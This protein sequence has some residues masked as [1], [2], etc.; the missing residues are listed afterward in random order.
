MET[1][2][3]K[4]FAFVQI[5]VR[6]KSSLWVSSKLDFPLTFSRSM[7]KTASVSI[8]HRK[9]LSWMIE[10]PS[11]RAVAR[12]YG[13]PLRFFRLVLLFLDDGS[14]K[15]VTSI[16]LRRYMS[17]NVFMLLLQNTEWRQAGQAGWQG[18][19]L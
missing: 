18:R 15:S 2:S 3:C 10:F 6:F 13:P 16:G 19:T 8:A 11:F 17:K 9:R 12:F 14:D 7:R 1:L 4:L 5:V